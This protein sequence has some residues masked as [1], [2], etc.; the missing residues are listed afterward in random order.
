MGYIGSI[1]ALD[2]ATL[3]AE[4]HALQCF[5]AG[6]YNAITTSLPSVGSVC[7]FGPD[8]FAARY[9]TAAC[10]NTLS[11]GLQK[12]QAARE[13][14]FALV[15]AL[16]SVWEK[17]F[18]APSM[19][20]STAGAFNMVC[21][22][23]RS[24][25]LDDSPQDKKQ[26]TATTLLRDE[27]CGQDFA[28][29]ISLRASKVLGP[30]SRFRV[31]EILRASRPVLTVDFLRIFCNGL[32]TARRF[33]TE[34]DNKRVELDVRMNPTLSLITTSVLA[35]TI[36]TSIWRQALVLP[37]TSH[38]LHD[39]MTQVFLFGIVVMGF[40]DAFDYARRQDRRSIENLGNF[41]FA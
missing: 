18:L 6:P 25:K 30:I 36:V 12:I 1:S 11:Q 26:K 33:H 8:R 41:G 2:K 15:L 9:R 40:I 24:G 4:A 10:S 20:R 32:C 22:L 5:T 38:L 14:D 27:L 23:D 39:L 28:R 7:G 3:K 35:C 19:A 31:V 16:S 17:E 34:G 13:I 21:C 37:A 29:P